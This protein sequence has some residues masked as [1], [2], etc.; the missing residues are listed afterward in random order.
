[1]AE[2]THI[3]DHLPALQTLSSDPNLLQGRFVSYY[4]V[5]S[6][7]NDYLTLLLLFF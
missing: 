2:L 6:T 1:M 3:F 7:F 5:H 4:L